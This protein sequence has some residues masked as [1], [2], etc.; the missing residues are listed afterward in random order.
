M[1]FFSNVK[2]YVLEWS[3]IGC[4]TDPYIQPSVSKSLS[5]SHR[6]VHTQGQR[7]V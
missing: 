5:P 6:I 1:D 4:S 7:K 3:I 2:T